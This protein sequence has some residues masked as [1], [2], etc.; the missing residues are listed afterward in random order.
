LSVKI[1][2]LPKLSH[3]FKESWIR[4]QWD[5]IKMYHATILVAGYLVA[6]IALPLV[7]WFMVTHK[8][9]LFGRSGSERFSMTDSEAA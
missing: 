3:P 4:I 7:G 9:E 2:D 6:G 1:C 8:S 5:E